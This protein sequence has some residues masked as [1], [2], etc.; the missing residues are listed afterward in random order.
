MLIAGT[1]T[2]PFRVLT[3]N[4]MRNNHLEQLR[5]EKKSINVIK[6]NFI[7]TENDASTTITTQLIEL[8]N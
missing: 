3:N 4:Y 6:N 7:F 8:I 5:D 1:S 2:K